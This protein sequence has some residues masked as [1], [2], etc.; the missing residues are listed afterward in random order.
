MKATD[1][2]STLGGSVS[3]SALVERVV[4]SCPFSYEYFSIGG[5]RS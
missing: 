5:G 3:G 1:E 2:G 4:G